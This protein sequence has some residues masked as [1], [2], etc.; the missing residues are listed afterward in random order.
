MSIRSLL[1]R[2]LIAILS[3]LAM[4]GLITWLVAK[5]AG[6]QNSQYFTTGV[7]AIVA[8][9][10]AVISI[11]FVYYDL[12]SRVRPF[13]SVGNITFYHSTSED[14]TQYSY[15]FPVRNT[16]QVP[17][18]DIQMRLRFIYSATRQIVNS[19][20]LSIPLLAP[21]AEQTVELIASR[22][23]PELNQKTYSDSMEFQIEIEYLGLGRRYHILQTYAIRQNK[24]TPPQIIFSIIPPC[25]MT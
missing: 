2:S 6:A 4:I 23:P 9:I 13:V 15:R 24:Q 16:G 7:A 5:W 18:T 22:L 11:I 14:P 21:S 17:A 3:L 8:A 12:E 25:N 1:W 20:P 19:I 10:A